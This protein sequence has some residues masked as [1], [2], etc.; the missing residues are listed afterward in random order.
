MTTD[1]F[2]TATILRVGSLLSRTPGV[3]NL[4]AKFPIALTGGRKWRIRGYTVECL[5]SIPGKEREMNLIRKSRRSLMRRICKALDLHHAK[6]SLLSSYALSDQEKVLLTRVSL[7]IH[8]N[9]ELYVP[10][11]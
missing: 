10:C 5:C 1:T 9:D 8:G 3:Y 6:R 2:G 4:S 11:R 7:K